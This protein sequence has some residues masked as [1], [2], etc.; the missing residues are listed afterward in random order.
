MDWMEFIANILESITWPLS[1][2]FVFFIFRSELKNLFHRLNNLKVKNIDFNFSE[3]NAEAAVIK[4]IDTKKDKKIK[5]NASFQEN[6]YKAIEEFPSHAIIIAWSEIE[7]TLNDI[8]KKHDLLPDGVLR[9]SSRQNVDSLIRKNI[10]AKEYRN[11]F[12]TLYDT[13]N[14]IVHNRRAS[15]NVTSDKAYDYV[16]TTIELLK[17]LKSL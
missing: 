10:L 8:V 1:I 2:F 7:Q 5:I 13:R 3:V 4:N 11:L 15:M 6:V 16:E 17:H 14:V 9:R 12:F